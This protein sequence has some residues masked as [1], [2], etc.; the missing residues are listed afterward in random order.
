MPGNPFLVESRLPTGQAAR[1]TR[2][3]LLPV[4]LLVR[5]FLTAAIPVFASATLSNERWHLKII[6]KLLRT[7]QPPGAEHAERREPAPPAP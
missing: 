7:L 2:A 3:M 6:A 4:A 1:S 5:I